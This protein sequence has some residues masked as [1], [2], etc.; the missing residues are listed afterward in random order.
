MLLLLL[1]LLLLVLLL[2]KLINNCTLL[3]YS[4]NDGLEINLNIQ[5]SDILLRSQLLVATSRIANS[6]IAVVAVVAFVVI[7]INS[8]FIT[9]I[10]SSCQCVCG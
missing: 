4:P 1:L 2:H 8:F 9:I 6:V 3:D 7:A 10:S 5:I